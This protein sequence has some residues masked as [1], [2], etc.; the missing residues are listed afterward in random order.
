MEDGECPV[1]YHTAGLAA[2]SPTPDDPTQRLSLLSSLTITGGFNLWEATRSTA[3]N[4]T[5]EH[6]AQPSPLARAS[7]QAALKSGMRAP[8]PAHGNPVS[9][10]ERGE[11][12]WHRPP[13]PPSTVQGVFEAE[14]MPAAAAASVKSP[15]VGGMED[16]A[17][18]TRT[19]RAD[20][21]PAT[22]SNPRRRTVRPTTSSSK[23][24]KS[25]V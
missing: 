16:P 12:L 4:D 20:A 23:S 3:S 2:P 25:R 15:E 19:A 10:E 6:S 1:H 17:H 13:P 7:R 14:G 5:V 8:M 22:N 11:V 21:A 24:A 18:A 9:D